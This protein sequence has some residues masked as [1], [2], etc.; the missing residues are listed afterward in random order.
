MVV[1]HAHACAAA[2]IPAVIDPGRRALLACRERELGIRF[3]AAVAEWYAI[4]GAVERV[5]E[6]SIHDI[7]PLEQLGLAADGRDLAV[8]R[9][10]L[11]V[12]NQR[13]CDWVVPPPP[14]GLASYDVPLPG[15]R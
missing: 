8:G 3:P 2:G 10:L 5:A 1:F 15:W 12:E 6:H 13:C 4:P 7:V 9:L 11:G 14:A